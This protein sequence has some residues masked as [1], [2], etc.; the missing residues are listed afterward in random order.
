MYVGNFA[1][2]TTTLC[3]TPHLLN[4]GILPVSTKVERIQLQ[5]KSQFGLNFCCRIEHQVNSRLSVGCPQQCVRALHKIQ[6]KLLWYRAYRLKRLKVWTLAI[7]LLTW[8]RL[9]NSSAL[10]Y[11]SGSWLAWANDIGHPLPA[12][13]DNWTCSAASRHTTT[14]I[15]H[16]RPS[17]CSPRQVSYYSFPIPLR[18]GGWVGLST[19]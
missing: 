16:T 8:V 13:T 1:V 6:E 15:S 7:A 14:P 17:L 4:S 5:A 18:I 3:S 2:K 9:K 11:R 12:L 19:Q 10:Q